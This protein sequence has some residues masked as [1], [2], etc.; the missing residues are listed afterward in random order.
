MHE[1]RQILAHDFPGS[2][3]YFQPADIV[4]QVLNFGLSAPIDVQIEYP[5]LGKSYEIARRLR[6]AITLVPGTADAHIVQVLDYPSLDIAVDRQRAAQVGISERDVANNMLISLSSS[7]LV[8]PS[9]F[10]NP[11]NNVNYSVVVKTP[12][13]DLGSVE[14]LMQTPITVPG[15]SV[16]QGDSGAAA[17]LGAPPEASAVVL[18]GIA[19]IRP[20]GTPVEINHYTVQRVLDIAAS[21]EN[22]D[23]GAVAS[24]IERKI[25]A[26]G[27]L[28]ANM[29]ITVRG[30]NQVMNQSFRSL[31]LGLVLAIVL[32]YLLMVVLYQSWLDPFI[33]MVAVPGALVGILWMLALTHT[34]LNVESLMG[35]IMAVGI[36]VANSILVVSF[37]NELRVESDR[38][39]SPVEAALE[40]G[41]TRLRP[42]LMTALAM[43]IGMVPMALG[44]GEAGEQN[45]PLGRAVIGGLVVATFVTLFIVPTVYASLRVKLP[46]KHVIEE[47]FL[48]EERG[49]EHA[50]SPA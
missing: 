9:Y 49:A 39:I 48:A 18:S 42:V 21:V 43:I 34:T 13:R 23:L 45:A 3:A 4:S 41:R 37:A 27:P 32:V 35:A 25:E 1:I 46:T 16:L 14:R 28:P 50:R 47:R 22:R 5:D 30:Q 44:L 24:D 10:L 26:L 20:S 15:A 6:D 12:L 33:I 17:S 38:V 8:A 11:A 29:R 31:G 7:G 40:A 36:A 2:T 19:D